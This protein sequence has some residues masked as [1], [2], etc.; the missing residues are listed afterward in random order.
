M[1]KTPSVKILIV[2]DLED[3]LL[4]LE[5]LLARDGYEILTAQSGRQALELLLVHDV[6]LA[7]L[8]VQMPEMDG[9]ELAEL[10]RGAARTRFVPIIFVT[11]SAR[12]TWRVFRGYEVGAVDFLFKPLDPVLLGHKVTTFAELHLQRLE[13]E[14]LA[15]ELR[16]SLRLNEM[17]LAVV[18]HDL[19]SPLSTVVMGATLL[20]R[21]LEDPTM[22]RT[23]ARMRSSAER[24]GGMLG[25]LYELARARLGGGISIERR[26]MDF[27]ALADRVI[28]ELRLAYPGVTVTVHYDGEALTGSWDEE[29]LSQVLTNLVGNACRYGTRE[30][31]VTVDVRA[32]ETLLVAEV[33]NGGEIAADL[34]PQLFE[35]FR[36]GSTSARDGLGLGLYI[37]R[38]I[39]QAHGGSVE[40]RSSK[41][42]G[43]TFHLELPRSHTAAAQSA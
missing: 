41:E 5:A 42:A 40:V 39:A 16:E 15:D 31:G 11:A 30:E 23:V 19:R 8:D 1:T 25:Q 14:R 20:D 4:A 10:M 12:E 27:R 22:K 7:L 33:H 35:P 26:A 32:T 2:D 24:M 28:D 21:E 38:Q 13:R 3:N 18:C 36:R 9:F 34:L 29:R 17:F 37:V 6:A 43:T